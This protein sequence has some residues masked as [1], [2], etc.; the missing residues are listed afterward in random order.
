MKKYQR[1]EQKGS[2]DACSDVRKDDDDQQASNHIV[3]AIDKCNLAGCKYWPTRYSGGPLNMIGWWPASKR[4]HKI[5]SQTT[6]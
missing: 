5:F 1:E 2:G 3:H 6:P 4:C